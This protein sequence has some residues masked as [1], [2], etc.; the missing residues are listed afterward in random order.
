[1]TAPGNRVRYN[2]S[3]L[4]DV[5][6]LL[7]AAQPRAADYLGQAPVLAVLACGKFS[8]HI[9]YGELDQFAATIASGPKLRDVMAAYG[10]SA[11]M[12]KIGA[13]GLRLRDRAA[14][15]ALHKLDASTLSQSIPS[16]SQRTW[17]DG[18]DKW[19][20][21]T[22]RNKRDR[23]RFSVAWIARRLGE[24][25]S[26]FEQV[27]ALVDYIGRGKQELNERWSW[28]RAMQAVADWHRQLRDET[29]LRRLAAYEREALTFDK[30][31]C[32]SAL[33]DSAEV[34]GF[35]FR[36]LR[37]L[38]HLRDE[39][40][41]MHHCVASYAADVRKGRCTIVSV[42]RDGVGVGTLQIDARG[43]VVQLKAHCNAA[44]SPAVR[45]ACDVYA[46][47]HWRKPEQGA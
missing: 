7:V 1:M 25:L 30:V 36:V 9:T 4:D 12:R 11:P 32:N 26:R 17:L 2:D 33:P 37:T 35:T 18:V 23:S 20:R 41:A 46:L 44:V 45:R 29:M 16:D 19:L 15:V 34:E 13:T 21:L 14:L 40:N 10:A 42:T 3:F 39:G 28:D 27:D 31:I 24:N 47:L 8:T 38:R 6:G 22:P 43:S 5:A